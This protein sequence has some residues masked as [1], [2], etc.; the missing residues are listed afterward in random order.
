MRFF[1]TAGP[2]EHE[3]HYCIPPLERVDLEEVLSLVDQ[4]KYFVLHA[5][6]QTGKTSTL[7]AL[8]NLLNA[9]GRYRCVYANVEAAQTARDDVEQA[10]RIVLGVLASRARVALG[11]DFL[12]KEWPGIFAEF[13]PAALGEALTRWCQAG[14]RPLVLLIDEIDALVGD[15]L[16]SALRQLRSGYD[17]RPRAFPQS[18]ALCGVRDVR[19]YRIRSGPADEV[20]TGGSA[21]NVKAKSL[22]LGDF[23]RADATALLQQ[24]TAET[25]QPFASEALDLVWRQT[26]G[27][28]WLVNALAA[29]ACF[30]NKAGRERS[31][32]IG[33]NAVRSAQE[34]LIARR[35]TH[36]DQLADKL[37]EERVR[38]VVEPML[39]GSDETE[40]ADRDLEYV[41][42]LGLVAANRPLRVANPI[43]AEVIP[44]ELTWVAQEQMEADPAWYVDDEGR[45]NM[46]GLLEAFQI[47]FR[48]NSEHWLSRF[49]YREAGPQLLLQAFLQRVVNSGGRIEREY[50]LGRWRTDLLVLWPLAEGGGEQRFVIEC[51]VLRSSRKRTVA[52]GLEQTARYMDRCDADAGHLI[53]FDRREGRSWT[54]KI[55]RRAETLAD[56]PEIEVWGM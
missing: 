18:L 47:F 9:Q 11:D 5:P 36:L 28:P 15:S 52:K 49:Q 53:V 21:F 45:L 17:Q 27:Q 32:V 38:R 2:V 56:G 51:K 8:R 24:H 3:R 10:V 55:F 22:R 50:G 48:A 23:S 13:G 33:A 29:E 46:P 14:D 16:L 20:V 6:R 39:S 19:D 31:R 1:N 43:Y 25:G 4:R 54:D 40:F 12:A 26:Q 30:E 37:K 41:R 42:D 7:L 34:R 35:E 44:R